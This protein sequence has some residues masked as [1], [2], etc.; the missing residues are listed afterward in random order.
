MPEYEKKYKSRLFYG[1][2]VLAASFVILLFNSGARFI[3]GVM[4][5]PMAVE[6]GW[7]RSSISLA[8]FLFMTIYALSITIVGK[9][10]DRYGPKWVIIISS[11]FLLAGYTSLAYITS[12]WHFL[13]SYGIIAPVGLGGTS[14]A[15]FSALMSKW[16]E[17]YRGLAISLALSG[18]CL[19]Q[20]V[21]VP[22]FTLFV[23]RYDWR[24]PC[25]W[26][27][28]IM[29]GVNVILA[30]LVIKGD[31]E[32]LGI[33]PFGS[34]DIDKGCVGTIRP[35]SRVIPSDLGLSE[36]MGTSSFW[37]F[38]LVMFV[39]GSGDFLITTHLIPFVT[40]HGISPVTAGNMLAWLGLMSLAG[41]L[42]AGPVSDLIGNKIPIAV[43]FLLRVF[44]FLFILKYQ[45]PFSFYLFSLLFGL[46]FLVTAPLTPTLI[47]RLYGLSHVGILSG[48]ITTVHH[49]GGGFW[50]YIG[51]LLFDRT[52]NYQS[53]FFISAIMAFIAFMCS[54][55]IKE[56]RYE[57]SNKGG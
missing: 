44:L 14:V 11:I 2:Y 25:L 57:I 13:V 22:V 1:W 42:I 46:S 45:D 35:P 31:P 28:I 38:L 29:L 24:I 43:T 32:S 19:G 47:G 5:K 30:A 20:F 4:F 37:L 15:M 9:F 53:A 55:L 7:D 3:I 8:F 49:L 48:F 39:C 36:A 34:G 21:L 26:L 40:D 17:K 56:K 12:Y 52:G 6:F 54:I 10:Y 41:I 33:S 27:G 50:T 18:N 23:L 16:F 51:G